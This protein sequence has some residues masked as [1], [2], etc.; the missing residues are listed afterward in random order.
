[1]TKAMHKL[2][3]DWKLRNETCS[4]HKGMV[5]CA[6]VKYEALNLRGFCL[7]RKVLS[8]HSWVW[9]MGGVNEGAHEEMTS[10]RMLGRI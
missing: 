7:S 1:M 9:Q 4:L 3:Q 8:C 10:F 6:G 5:C 2:S